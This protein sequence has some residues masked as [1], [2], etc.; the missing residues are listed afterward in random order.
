MNRI[1]R[2][3]KMYGCIISFL[4]VCLMTKTFMMAFFSPKKEILV[5]INTVGEAN[6]EFV[7]LFLVV[8]IVAYTCWSYLKILHN[9]KDD[10]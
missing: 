7:M 9:E 2:I 3:I 4:F 6:P 8:P 1:D 5:T 10:I